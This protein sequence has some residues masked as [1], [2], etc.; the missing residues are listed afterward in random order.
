[1]T[2][3]DDDMLDLIWIYKKC[4]QSVNE[5]IHKHTPNL[6]L[7]P[8]LIPIHR[9]L[10]IK[11]ISMIIAQS[12]KWIT[13]ITMTMNCTTL[14]GEKIKHSRHASSTR[15]MSLDELLLLY[16]HIENIHHI[17]VVWLLI[18]R[19]KQ[20]KN[21]KR[22]KA[23]MYTYGLI[24]KIATKTDNNARVEK[25]KLSG[26]FKIKKLF[27]TCHITHS[28]N[29]QMHRPDVS[30]SLTYDNDIIIIYTDMMTLYCFRFIKQHSL[31]IFFY[32]SIYIDFPCR[33]CL[34]MNRWSLRSKIEE[35]SVKSSE[36]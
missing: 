18:M 13:M 35:K 4:D 11:L 1:M 29:Q 7:V 31:E 25:K 28:R 9:Q 15:S 14:S 16:T 30:A 33:I 26:S 10:L 20:R 34:H 6:H 24:C 27:G 2:L 36:R 5:F 21:L 22:T 12:V 8:C 17:I 3:T 32:Q 19:V 23:Y